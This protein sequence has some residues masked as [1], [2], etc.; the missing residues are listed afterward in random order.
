MVEISVEHVLMFVIVAFLL[1]HFM[2]G[3]G[4]TN[5]GDG[6]SV[7]GINYLGV[8]TNIITNFCYESGDTCSGDFYKKNKEN[9]LL[10]KC[11]P[12]PEA[13]CTDDANEECNGQNCPTCD[14]F[15]EKNMGLQI[16]GDTINIQPMNCNNIHIA[17]ECEKKYIDLW[18]NN[19]SNIEWDNGSFTGATYEKGDLSW[20]TTAHHGIVI[21]GNER[22]IRDICDSRGEAM[23]LSQKISSRCNENIEKLF[24]DISKYD[25]NASDSKLIKDVKDTIIDINKE[26]GEACC[27][28]TKKCTPDQISKLQENYLEKIASDK[29]CSSKKCNKYENCIGIYNST[30]NT[31]GAKCKC[32]QEILQNGD[33]GP[34]TCKGQGFGDPSSKML[35]SYGQKCIL[36]AND[37]SM[38]GFGNYKCIFV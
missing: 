8:D 2:S 23:E 18:E 20:T 5:R 30:S 29:Y 37:P 22:N 15:I 13:D 24:N 33:C 28:S 7:G 19:A 4:C 35:C 6:F 27:G 12:G 10:Y 26:Y 36:D 9:N 11:V 3:C 34:V 21:H 14:A 32:T 16:D 38:P 25:I 17:Q 1:Y 31:L